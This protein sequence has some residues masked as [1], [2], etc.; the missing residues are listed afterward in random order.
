MVVSHRRN[1][2]HRG[3]CQVCSLHLLAQ[4]PAHSP[5]TLHCLQL[6]ASHT[7]TQGKENKP[8]H[9]PPIKEFSLKS[10]GTGASYHVSTFR[11]TQLWK[12]AQ[13]LLFDL[14]K[15]TPCF[16]KAIKRFHVPYCDSQRVHLTEFLPLHTVFPVSM[17]TR[18]I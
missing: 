7:H 13:Y 4:G 17:E 1:P 12:R 5:L 8:L 3:A 2:G 6:S 9:V 16:Q 18:L 14:T 11:V 15:V 10:P